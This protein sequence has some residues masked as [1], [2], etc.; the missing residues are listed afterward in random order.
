MWWVQETSTMNLASA[1]L[2]LALAGVG[3][4]EVKRYGDFPFPEVSYQLGFCSCGLGVE[5]WLTIFAQ[6]HLQHEI[7]FFLDT[8]LDTFPNQLTQSEEYLSLVDTGFFI[9]TSIMPL[10]KPE[11]KVD[12]ILHLNYSAGSQILVREIEVISASSSVSAFLDVFNTLVLLILLLLEVLT[13]I[14]SSL[15]LQCDTP[16]ISCTY[17]HLFFLCNMTALW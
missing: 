9:N 17:S 7:S 15:L 3:K 1:G 13:T 8:V 2:Q 4:T 10:L 12:V 16:F 6:L 5:N 14:T 11:R